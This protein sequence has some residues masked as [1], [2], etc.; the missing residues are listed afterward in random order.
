MFKEMRRRDRELSSAETEEIL[1]KGTYGILSMNGD[2]DYGYGVPL[3]YVYTAG[4]IYLHCAPEG[5]KL[6]RI[7][8]DNRVT[9][10]VVGEAVPLPDIFAMK[11]TSAIAFGKAGEVDGDEK[12][13]AL[14]GFVKKYSTDEYLE[15]GRQYAETAF[16]KTALIKIAV[17]HMTGKGRK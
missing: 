2:N 14:I 15:K 3:S 1:V 5:H 11:Y 10:C 7:R 8:N 13:T 12:M 9:F 6:D 4:S 17:E 16:K